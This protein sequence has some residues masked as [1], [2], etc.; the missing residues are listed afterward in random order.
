MLGLGGFKE[1]AVFETLK[2]FLAEFERLDIAVS[3]LQRSGWE[4]LKPLLEG[5]LSEVRILCTD[6][7]GISDPAAI[8]DMLASGVQ[9]RAYGGNAVFHPKV[10]LIS[11][12]D[13]P[14]AWLLGSANLSRSALKTA[15]TGTPSPPRECR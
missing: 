14:D 2:E 6:Q 12:T 1:G 4:L 8:R 5:K 15:V 9:V 3:Y 7:L 13:K 11:N 10:Y